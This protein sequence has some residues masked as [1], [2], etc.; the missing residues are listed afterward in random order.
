MQSLFSN[1]GLDGKLLL[2]QAVN[3]LVVFFVLKTFVYKPLMKML[4]HRRHEI[5]AGLQKSR[6]ADQRLKE[7]TEVQR[8]KL[9]EA[10]EEAH[11][12]M[13]AAGEKAKIAEKKML[14]EV[15]KKQAELLAQ[16]TVR[17]EHE[18]NLILSEA[19][20]AA[21]ELVKKVLIEAVGVKP[22]GVDNVLIQKIAEAEKTK[23]EKKHG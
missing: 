21:A 19:G 7:I 3:F 16:A 13:V 1:L 23:R 14:S 20:Q 22:E 5:E 8:E 15:D 12:L 4:A 6:E 17:A 9:K 2:A 11:K 18:S 10:E